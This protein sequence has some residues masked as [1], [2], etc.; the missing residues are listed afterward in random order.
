MSISSERS[1]HSG[2]RRSWAPSHEIDPSL[3]T[4]PSLRCACGEM[5]RS[6]VARTTR[7]NGRRFLVCSRDVSLL[8]L[9]R[10]SVFFDLPCSCVI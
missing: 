8:L 9:L 5:A 2:R 7:N 4:E 1:A 3:G 10:F 6:V